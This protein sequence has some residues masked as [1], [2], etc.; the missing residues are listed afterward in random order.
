MKREVEV[1]LGQGEG[2]L[3]VKKNMRNSEV[4]GKA[5]EGDSLHGNSGREAQW[6]LL[7]EGQRRQAS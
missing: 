5:S 7:G 4:V 3:L 6:L 1:S 2:G